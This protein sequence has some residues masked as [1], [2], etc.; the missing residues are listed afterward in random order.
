MSDD[1]DAFVDHLKRCRGVGG[2]VAMDR[3]VSSDPT[4]AKLIAEGWT[5]E[6]EERLMGK[7]IRY[8]RPPEG[9]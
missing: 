5:F 4:V 9:S 3:G 7:R 2:V 1:L 8:L 6:G